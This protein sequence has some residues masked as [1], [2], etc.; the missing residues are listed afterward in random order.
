MFSVSFSDTYIMKGSR[1]SHMGFIISL[2]ALQLLISGCAS[3]CEFENTLMFMSKHDFKE[4]CIVMNEPAELAGKEFCM[5]EVPPA[6]H[7]AGLGPSD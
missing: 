6:Q 7:R 2:A 1:I 5:R 3:T 4:V